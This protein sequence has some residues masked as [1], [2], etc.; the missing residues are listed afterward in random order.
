M[1]II[2]TDFMVKG[3]KNGNT[4]YIVKNEEGNY[5]VYQLFC[6]TNKDTTVKSIKKILP[7]LKNLRDEQIIVSFPNEQQKAFLL[8]H[9]VDIYEMNGFRITLKDEN[10]LTELL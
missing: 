5:N 6:D 2:K 3:H 10:I 1:K 9:N 4:H 8:L 7:S